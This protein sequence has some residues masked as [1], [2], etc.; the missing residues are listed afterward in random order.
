M[1]TFRVL[2]DFWQKLEATQVSAIFAPASDAFEQWQ[3]IQSLREQ[4][5]RVIVGLAGQVE[6]Y[7]YQDCD[8]LLI[9]KKW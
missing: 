3:A 6:P 1:W 5:Q 8:R 2:L 9:E 4:G 7:D